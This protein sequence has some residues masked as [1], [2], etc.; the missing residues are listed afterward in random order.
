[1]SI[2][3]PQPLVTQGHLPRP[4]VFS[5]ALG[6]SSAAA[7]VA[8][9]NL[10]SRVRPRTRILVRYDGKATW[11]ER[12]ALAEISAHYF[13]VLTPDGD[14][15]LMR[16]TDTRYTDVKLVPPSGG[17]PAGVVDGARIVRFPAPVVATALS[18]WMM[19]GEKQARKERATE[20]KAR[21]DA[22]VAAV[23]ALGPAPPPAR[24]PGSPG[25]ADDAGGYVPPE[26]WKWL[27]CE[28]KDGLSL[29]AESDVPKSSLRE[30]GL[31]RGAGGLPVL[32]E[33]VDPTKVTE[34]TERV[35]PKTAD[36]DDKTP[37]MP[38]DARI[39]QARKN[40]RGQPY[41]AFRYVIQ[42]CEET[43]L[44]GWQVEGPRVTTWALNFLKRRNCP[45]SDHHRWWLT[46]CDLLPSDWGVSE[47][48][49]ALHIIE[50]FACYDQVDLTN[51]NG[52][53]ALFRRVM[54]IEWQY[55]EKIKDRARGSVSASG[56]VSGSAPLTSDEYDLFEG[57]GKTNMSLM[58]APALVQ[59]I[60]DEMKRDSD[61]TRTAR[62]ARE[63]KLMAATGL[64]VDD[65][66]GL[67]GKAGK[68]GNGEAGGDADARGSRRDR[69]R[70][71]GKP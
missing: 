20:I 11:W 10:L 64:S 35:L 2:F 26:G 7:M 27:V 34:W 3:L 19:E 47:H 45:P 5:P 8:A 41:R 39:L 24:E 36:D 15:E 40:D 22:A 4:L 25:P 66:M 53:E 49:S 23:R 55:R 13:V 46:C 29:G 52:I 70:Q 28:N 30:R 43:E 68:G 48:A 62:K 54:A 16:L 1:M 51:L 9:L 50:L 18:D 61:V 56:S 65:I 59:Y 58:V 69:R 31:V 37:V 71:Q 33:L 67:I 17:R 63:E 44:G 57:A 12:L 6:P 32:V 21:C 14:T 42:D 38:E 60:A